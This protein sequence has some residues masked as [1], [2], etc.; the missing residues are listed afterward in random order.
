MAVPVLAGV[1]WDAVV[2]TLAIAIPG[3]PP[4]ICTD[5]IASLSAALSSVCIGPKFLCIMCIDPK[6]LGISV[7][8]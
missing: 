7:H 8:R 1:R 4:R 3:V 6:N 5:A 2:A